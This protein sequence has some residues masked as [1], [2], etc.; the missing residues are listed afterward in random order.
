MF[1]EHP[2]SGLGM[3][4]VRVPVG[5]RHGD[6]ESINVSHGISPVSAWERAK[7]LVPLPDGTRHAD[8]P[9]LLECHLIG[10]FRL[11]PMIALRGDAAWTDSRAVACAATSEL[12]RRD[13][14]TGS[15]FVTVSTAASIM[16]PFFTLPRCSLG[17]W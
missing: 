14:H 8:A 16:G 3:L 9:M 13:S 12:W 6:N 11:E 15:A 2:R 4:A 7:I 5:R 10:S 17:M 1:F